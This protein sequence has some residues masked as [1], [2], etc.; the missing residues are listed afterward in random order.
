[1][2]STHHKHSPGHH[3][4]DAGI[5][6]DSG[7]NVSIFGAVTSMDDVE[8]R[9]N[10][11]VHVDAA[12]TALDDLKVEA[13]GNLTI[14]ANVDLVAGDDVGLDSR[15]DMM[16]S[17]DIRSGDDVEL[18]AFSDMEIS[19]T[20]EADHILLSAKDNLTLSSQ[21]YLTGIDGKAAKHVHLYAGGAMVLDGAI[22]A[23]R[24]II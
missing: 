15:A 10:G 9:A 17:G 5:R 7:S 1:L 16:V 6:I 19:G 20:I 22:D 3:H 23:E 21:S 18:S 8:L 12:I 4:H 11:S 24:L 14:T 2:T 13:N